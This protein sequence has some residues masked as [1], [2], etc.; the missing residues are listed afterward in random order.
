MRAVPSALHCAR[1]RLSVTVPTAFSSATLCRRLATSADGSTK[2]DASAAPRSGPLSGIRVLDLSRILAGPY[3]SQVLCDYGADVI[4][5]EHPASGDDTRAW[6]PPFTAKGR[7]SAYFLSVNRG[8]RSVCI[9]LKAERGK[10]LIR[11][12]AEQCDVL[13]ENFIPGKVRRTLRCSTAC[14][15]R[16]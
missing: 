11:R 1:C 12:L 2:S 13:M 4:K 8:K 10:Q 9:D 7:M 3:C 16:R 5:I 15:R 14:A 6:G